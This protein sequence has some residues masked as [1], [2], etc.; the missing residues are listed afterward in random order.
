LFWRRFSTP[1]GS[2]HSFFCLM[3]VPYT[4]AATKGDH[5]LSFNLTHVTPPNLFP[6]QFIS[7]QCAPSTLALIYKG[8]RL[9]PPRYPPPDFTRWNC[10]DLFFQWALNNMWTLFPPSRPLVPGCPPAVGTDSENYSSLSRV[11]LVGGLQFFLL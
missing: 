6:I 11:L 7:D 2:F 3:N 9:L 5:H 1:F 4:G 10:S 8:V